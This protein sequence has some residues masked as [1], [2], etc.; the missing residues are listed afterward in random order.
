MTIRKRMALPLA[1]AMAAVVVMVVAS[2][3]NA[4]HVRPKSASPLTVSLVP[5]FNACTTAE[6]PARTASGVPVL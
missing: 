6:P 4:G 1:L 2:M 5:G 3:A